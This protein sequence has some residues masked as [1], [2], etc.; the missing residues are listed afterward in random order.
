M[1]F[2]FFSFTICLY[3][4][5]LTLFGFCSDLICDLTNVVHPL[6]WQYNEGLL[7]SHCSLVSK[8]ILCY[9]QVT[10]FLSTCTNIL[11]YCTR[12]KEHDPVGA[13][14]MTHVLPFEHASWRT[15]TYGWLVLQNKSQKSGMLARLG[16]RI[17]T[18]TIPIKQ[19]TIVFCGYAT[20][21]IT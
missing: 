18:Y 5:N 20:L 11:M 3:W 4:Y 2:S 15:E 9:L 1:D 13:P 19:D 6:V 7:T 14:S 17:N 16:H 8:P 12:F 21:K 10:W